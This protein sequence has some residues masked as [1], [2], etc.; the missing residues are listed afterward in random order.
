MV[1]K[2]LNRGL[3]DVAKGFSKISAISAKVKYLFSL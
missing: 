1:P 3:Y 2:T